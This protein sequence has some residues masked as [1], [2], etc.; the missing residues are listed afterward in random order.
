MPEQLKKIL[1]LLELFVFRQLLLNERLL[2]YSPFGYS[3]RY[4]F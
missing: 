3:L 1:T 4:T 2:L